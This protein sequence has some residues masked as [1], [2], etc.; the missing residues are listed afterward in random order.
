MRI[1]QERQRARRQEEIDMLSGRDR[2]S[3][4]SHARGERI[5]NNSMSNSN[6]GGSS[7]LK[8]GGLRNVLGKAAKRRGCAP[9]PLGGTSDDKAKT[10]GS[11]SLS[12]SF[13]LSKGTASFLD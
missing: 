4:S 5:S 6:C 12:N 11:R 10:N 2:A 1:K 13:T 8:T 9:A 3:R 7:S